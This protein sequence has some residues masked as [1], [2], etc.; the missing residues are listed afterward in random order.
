MAVPISAEMVC[1]ANGEFGAITFAL[2]IKKDSSMDWVTLK[3]LK[4]SNPNEVAKFAVA[5]C[6]MEEPT[7]NWWVQKCYDGRTESFQR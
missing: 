7:Y 1:S 5:N 6:L 3:E 2:S 4:E